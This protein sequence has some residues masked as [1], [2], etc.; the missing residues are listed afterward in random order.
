[1]GS[2]S[3]SKCQE[4]KVF[5]L[6]SPCTGTWRVFMNELRAWGRRC[7]VTCRTLLCPTVSRALGELWK[8]LGAFSVF[9]Q[10]EG[11]HVLH[12]VSAVCGQLPVPQPHG[13]AQEPVFSP[14]CR[15]YSSGHRLQV[16]F[17]TWI[18]TSVDTTP[19]NIC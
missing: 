13:P 9:S 8:P 6:V 1:M 17:G 5:V 18:V 12:W 4:D 15:E 2:H 14:M 16:G 10:T 7:W 19:R 11:S 3:G